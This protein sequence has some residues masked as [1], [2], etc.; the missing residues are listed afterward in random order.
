VLTSDI[1]GIREQVGDAAL[2]ACPTSMEAIADVIYRF[3][4]DRGTWAYP[5][6][7]WTSTIVCLHPRRLSSPSRRDL[8]REERA[9]SFRETTTRQ[10]RKIYEDV[11]E[12][13]SCYPCRVS[14]HSRTTYVIASNDDDPSRCAVPIVELQTTNNICC[15]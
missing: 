14:E 1:R 13:L 4:T 7:I 3:W 5:V 8:R 6:R 9:G 12:L 15:E 10:E 11:S 2:L